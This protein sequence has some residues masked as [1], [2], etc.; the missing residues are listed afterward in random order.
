LSR[1]FTPLSEP[2]YDYLLAN[3]LRE[4][5]ALARLREETAKEPMAQMQIAPDQGQF[6]AF[7]VRLTGARRALEV[8]TYTGY[9]ALA[10]ALALPAGGHLVAL[11]RSA[12]WTAI[13]ERHWLKAGVSDKITL[14]LGEA[15]R[16]LDEL[17]AE[18]EAGRFDFAFIDADKENYDAY[19]ERCLMLVRTG[20]LI[21][22]DNVLWNGA[23]ADPTAHDADTEAIRRLN[24]KLKDDERIDLSL[25]PIADGL[26]LARRRV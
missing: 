9:S 11:D 17:I 22:I 26:T 2:L 15:L 19:Y 25:V 13:A 8:G 23:V 18:G 4:P 7:L 6:M 21:A 20:G 12:E 3:S 16:S 10:V 14:M 24:A 1:T 5:K